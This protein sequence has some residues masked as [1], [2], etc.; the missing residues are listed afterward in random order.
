M[1]SVVIPF[2]NDEYFY[3]RHNIINY[4]LQD[5]IDNLSKHLIKSEIIIIDQG[6]K[7]CN[8]FFS[9][10]FNIKIIKPVS[11][12]ILKI[13][14]LSKIKA[15]HYGAALGYGIKHAKYDNI[16][17]KNA[18][19]MFDSKIYDFLKIKKNLNKNFFTAIRADLN[20]FSKNIKINYFSKVKFNITNNQ[21]FR[22]RALF[23]NACGDFILT[24]KLFLLNCKKFQKH[25]FHNDTF[26]L[27]KLKYFGLTQKILKNSHV[28]KIL[29]NNTFNKREIKMELN[30]AQKLLEKIFYILNFRENHLNI[31]RGILN[32]PKTKSGK[33]SFHR[34][35]LRLRF[36]MYL[37]DSIRIGCNNYILKNKSYFY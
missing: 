22:D 9:N 18:D 37:K 24:K 5:L 10:F 23:A 4:A 17:I 21:F 20:N 2:S 34:L 29:H 11:L 14:N 25:G 32:Y 35:C 3:K 30:L 6:G 28:I 13:D 15:F 12:K 8:L 33:E 26:I 36:N 27:F 16:L 31:I 19:T 7:S 1:I